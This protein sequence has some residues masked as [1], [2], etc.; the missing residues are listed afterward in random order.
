MDKRYLRKGGEEVLGR[1][2][3]ALVRAPDGEPRYFISQVEPVDDMRSVD[4]PAATPRSG[5]RRPARTP[6]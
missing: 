4:A 1:L 6:R 3:V 5:G 2:T